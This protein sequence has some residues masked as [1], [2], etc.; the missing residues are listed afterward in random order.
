M[1]SLNSILIE[2]ELVDDPVISIASEGRTLTSFT[3][4]SHRWD[5]VDGTLT[6]HPIRVPVL[7]ES[8]LAEVC[9]E[10]LK[11][12]RGVRVV[13]RLATAEREIGPLLVNMPYIHAEHVEF[14]PTKQ[15]ADAEHA[16]AVAL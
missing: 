2:G 11:K 10:Y 6:D 5:K 7:T 13:G 4:R 3:V 12:G 16:E 1:N 15:K 8:R 9:G 14:K